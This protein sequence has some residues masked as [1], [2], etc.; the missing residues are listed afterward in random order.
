MVGD[1]WVSRGEEG[2]VVGEVKNDRT[3][4]HESGLVEESASNG[5]YYL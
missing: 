5:G 2:G 4:I 1:E 3:M